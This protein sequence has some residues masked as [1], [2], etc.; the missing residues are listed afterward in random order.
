MTTRLPR[1]PRHVLAVPLFLVCA[2]GYADAGQSSSEAATVE[3]SGSATVLAIPDRA[4][5]SAAIE[6]VHED[7][8]RASGE[9]N[10]IAEQYVRTLR[11]LGSE[12]RHISS[13][14]IRLVP[15]YRW[16]KETEARERT[17][18]RAHRQVIVRVQDID[19]LGLYLGRASTSGMT[20]IEPPSLFVEAADIHTREALTK[21]TADARANAEAVA[22]G[23][24][25]QLGRVVSLD[26]RQ[27]RSGGG[28]Q[29]VMMMRSQ[30]MEDSASP[31]VD[32]GEIRFDAEVSARFQLLD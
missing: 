15:E 18:Y 27:G 4:E 6:V 16:N 20:H 28:P 7:A 3:V 8:Q 14:A 26:A 25:R 9:A 29:P 1:L 30:A 11:E 12:A 2:V 10:R 19:K 21:A 32:T 22:N 23:L 17:G 5:L 24:Q 13:S 31:S